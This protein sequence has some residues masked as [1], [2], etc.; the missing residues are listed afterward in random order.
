MF[1]V[2]LN[3]YEGILSLRHIIYDIKD[4]E[5]LEEVKEKYYKD[6]SKIGEDEFIL[7]ET[8]DDVNKTMEE[9]GLKNGGNMTQNTQD[10]QNMKIKKGKEK[11]YEEYVKKATDPYSAR[12]VSYAECWAQLLEIEIEKVFGLGTIVKTN[13]LEK[14][15]MEKAKETA[16]EAD[17]DGITGYMY[18]CAVNILANFWEYGDCIR[19]WHNASLGYSGKGTANSSIL[20]VKDQ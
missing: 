2:V 10:I 4:S 13:D 6:F 7:C 16:D 17:Y 9:H 12:V 14:L 18:N 20:H 1:C 19:K 15:I 11:E 5:T 8:M 3:K